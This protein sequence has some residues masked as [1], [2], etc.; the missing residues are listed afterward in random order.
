MARMAGKAVEE[1]LA[2]LRRTYAELRVILSTS[3]DARIREAFRKFAEAM[4]NFEQ[5]TGLDEPEAEIPPPGGFPEQPPG[6][7]DDASMLGL[8]KSVTKV[9]DELHVLNVNLEKYFADQI[10][11]AGG[12]R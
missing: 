2:E 9:G 8:V 11:L 7:K 1:S 5:A 3:T 6:P 4:A 12:K 10:R